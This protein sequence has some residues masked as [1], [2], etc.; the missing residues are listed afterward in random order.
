ME[1]KISNLTAADIVKLWTKGCEWKLNR[2]NYLIERDICSIEL[3]TD[4]SIILIDESI[5]EAKKYYAMIVF[6]GY[7]NYQKIEITSEQ[8]MSMIEL[9]Q[10]AITEKDIEIKNNFIKK[11]QLNLKMLM[12]V[13]NR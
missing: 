12:E 4:L 10:K 11:G 5:P 6:N 8:Y 3:T 13:V 2:E 7:I 9:L 1:N